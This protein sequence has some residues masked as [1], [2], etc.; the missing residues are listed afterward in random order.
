MINLAK[1]GF[2]N[3]FL[4]GIGASFQ[5]GAVG[6]VGRCPCC[7]NAVTVASTQQWGVNPVGFGATLGQQMGGFSPNPY[8]VAQ[9]L[10]I[11]QQNPLAFQAGIGQQHPLGFGAGIGQQNPLGFQAGIGQQNPLGFQ[12]GIGQQNPLGLGAG[13]GQQ[14]PFAFGAGITNPQ[15]MNP[16]TSQFTT[17]WP[18]S[19]LTHQGMG[20]R[21]GA[22]GVD[23]R[24]VAGQ[25]GY[26]DP[27][28]IAG[29]NPG[30]IGDPISQWLQ[31]QQVNQLTQQQLP[32]RS[33]FGGQQQ[34]IGGSGLTPG[35]ASPINQWND[36]YRAFIEAQLVSQLVQNPYHQLQRAYGLNEQ[37]GLGAPFGGQQFHSLF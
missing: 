33:L 26:N 25:V 12:A 7:G 23:P 13:I 20:G 14:N 29:L 11:G 6:S 4:S 37:F 28:L 22:Y 2:V 15:L 16:Y 10:G 3:P 24:L 9:T 17:N 1:Q 31:Q 19:Q 36:P 32:I 21:T 30:L 27:N 18:V 35:F 8:G 34:G 5:P